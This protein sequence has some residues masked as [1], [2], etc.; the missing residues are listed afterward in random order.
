M[1][2]SIISRI[3]LLFSTGFRL[4]LLPFL[5]SEII[6]S[7][8]LVCWSGEMRTV[9]TLV[10]FLF[11]VLIHINSVWHLKRSTWA[12]K[13]LIYQKGLVEY[14][15]PMFPIWN[16]LRKGVEE[17]VP[18]LGTFA[19]SFLFMEFAKKWIAWFFHHQMLLVQI[20]VLVQLEDKHQYQYS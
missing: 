15:L 8:N 19:D 11:L 14:V 9:K 13:K 7:N 3:I 10:N 6:A 18:Y 2:L 17:S 1:Y 4:L 5:Y 20:N 16:E 12:D